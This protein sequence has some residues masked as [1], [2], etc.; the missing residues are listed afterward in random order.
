MTLLETRSVCKYFGGLKAVD[1]VS[2]TVEKGKVFGIIGPNGAGKTTFF[3]VLTGSYQATD[4]QVVFKEQ[5]IT[6]LP[7][8]KIARLGIA[9][10]FQNIKLF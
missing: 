6:N 8:E 2:V 7:P 1:Q 5:P 10:T 3:N 9:R 4:G